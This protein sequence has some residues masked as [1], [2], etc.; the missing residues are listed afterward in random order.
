MHEAWRQHAL[1]MLIKLLANLIAGKND[2]EAFNCHLLLRQDPPVNFRV[3]TGGTGGGFQRFP[4]SISFPKLHPTF[5]NSEFV[6]PPS[7]P[8]HPGFLRGAK[9]GR[10]LL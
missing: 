10:S 4:V 2:N 6:I 7:L 3:L 8:W 1:K 9:A 5:G